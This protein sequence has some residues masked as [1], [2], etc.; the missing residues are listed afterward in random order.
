MKTP[1]NFIRNADRAK[2]HFIYITKDKLV[3]FLELMLERPH[4][5]SCVCRQCVGTIL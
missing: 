1:R 2:S 3:P 5:S 4:S